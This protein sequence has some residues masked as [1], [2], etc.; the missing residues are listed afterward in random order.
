ERGEQVVAVHVDG[1]ARGGADPDGVDVHAGLLGDGGG[2]DGGRVGPAGRGALILPVGGQHDRGGRPVAD[3]RDAPVAAE[4]DRPVRD[5]GQRGEDG[6]AE[7]R[8]A[9]G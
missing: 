1:R 7:R 6:V 4:A 5:R 3:G 9:A 8:A 2:R